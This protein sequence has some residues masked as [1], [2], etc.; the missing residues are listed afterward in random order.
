MVVLLTVFSG[1]NFAV[2]EDV[3]HRINKSHNLEY[4]V[5]FPEETGGGYVAGLEMFHQMH[6][7]NF[8]RQ[9]TYAEYYEEEIQAFT[10]G[11]ELLRLHLGKT[12]SL[13]MIWS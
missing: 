3:M 6:C 7:V 13:K 4:A 10:D 11:P 9:Y 5:K 1:G 8:L 12:S 2:D